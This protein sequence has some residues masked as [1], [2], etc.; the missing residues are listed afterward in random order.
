MIDSEGVLQ[1]DKSRMTFRFDQAKD[2]VAA[3]ADS[4]PFRQRRPFEYKTRKPRIRPQR[5]HRQGDGEVPQHLRL[6]WIIPAAFAAIIGIGLGL[7]ILFLF[8]SSASVS[9]P[10]VTTTGNEGQPAVS[11]PANSEPQ[12]LPGMSL[13]AYQVGV[14]GDQERA[15]KGAA[16]LEKIGLHPVQRIADQVQL[17]A[18]VAVGK[19]QGQA[20]AD[21]LTKQEAH[22]YLKEYTIAEKKGVMQ[23]ISTKD[24]A[25]LSGTLTLSAQVIK[26]GVALSVIQSPRKEAVDAW[27][28]R[29]QDLN[30]QA[31][32]A[33][34][35]LEKAGR[36]GELAR[37]ND[38]QQQLSDAASAM[39]AG[40]PI[41]DV[42]Q[43]IIQC[44][45]DY[46]ELLNKLITG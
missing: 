11:P 22:F 6:S 43:H 10:S 14:F 13:V 9:K 35:V 39:G 41:L 20:V 2:E 36:K 45:V 23:G 25:A 44:A 8:K 16:E 28:K 40:K 29:V 1:M 24:A 5:H 33:R 4:K 27:A 7:G 15:K 34:K 31:A 21:A 30:G 18:G 26:E 38:I 32:P 42:Q 12:T 46:E 3:A 37:F 17:F 19:E